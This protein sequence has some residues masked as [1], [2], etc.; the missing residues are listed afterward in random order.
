M[1]LSLSR[2]LLTCLSFQIQ[3]SIGETVWVKPLFDQKEELKIRRSKK[4]NKSESVGLHTSVRLDFICRGIAM[5]NS[6]HL[7]EMKKI[8][9]ASGFRCP[10]L[11][12]NNPI[13]GEE[14]VVVQSKAIINEL[15]I[16][17]NYFNI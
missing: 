1:K 13:N 10:E 8:V 15:Q 5:D 16:N 7:P 4:A 9:R 11:E 6:D 14:I 3:I 17:N 12:E 2:F